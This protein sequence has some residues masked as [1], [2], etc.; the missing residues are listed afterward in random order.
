M[1]SRLSS[2]VSHASYYDQAARNVGCMAEVLA[3]AG[4]DPAD[5]SRLGFYLIAP[6]KQFDEGAFAD[7]MTKES[8]RTKVNERVRAYE[9]S[10]DSWFAEWFEPTLNRLTLGCHS[11]EQLISDISRVNADDGRSLS[12]FYDLCIRFNTVS[13]VKVEV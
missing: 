7:L 8:I 6:Q 4:R 5:L 3:R 12:N 11:W 2:G 9:G 10:K 13:Q 1:F